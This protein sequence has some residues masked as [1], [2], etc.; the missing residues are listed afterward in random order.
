MHREGERER[1][2]EGE[3]K[4]ERKRGEKDSCKWIGITEFSGID[5]FSLIR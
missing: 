5:V 3:G 4:G 1:E 2:G